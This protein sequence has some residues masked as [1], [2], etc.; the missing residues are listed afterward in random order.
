MRAILNIVVA[1]LILN[2]ADEHFNDAQYTRAAVAM[3]SQI[4]RSFG[5]L[6]LPLIPLA[7]GPAVVARAWGV[8]VNKKPPPG[9]IGGGVRSY[10]VAVS[11]MPYDFHVSGS[12]YSRLTG[13]IDDNARL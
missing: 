10:G 9:A 3:L 5:W 11:A 2:F 8:L 7:P 1:L 6:P 13:A 12:T 4:A